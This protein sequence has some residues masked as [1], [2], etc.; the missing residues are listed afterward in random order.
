MPILTM[1]MSPRFR[2]IARWAA[3]T[4]LGVASAWNVSG[5]AADNVPA[6]TAPLG[7]N[8]IELGLDIDVVKTELQADSNFLFRGDPDVSMLSQPNESIIE[9]EGAIFVDRAYFQFH[10]RKLYTII[11]EL[12]PT[13]L[14][15]FTMYTTLVERFGEPSF[16]D[17]SEVVWEFDDTRVSLEHPLRVKY[18]DIRVL[19]TLSEAE[20]RIE[21][22]RRLSR[23]GFLDQF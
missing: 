17:P 16:L 9:T 7:F 22:L 20:R 10:E 19:D 3:L 21:S 13:R 12:N 18:I 14:D 15:H 11:L 2:W 8:L 4:A 5:Q 6:I 1:M 23:D